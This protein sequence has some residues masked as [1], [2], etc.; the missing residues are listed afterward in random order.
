MKRRTLLQSALALSVPA[1]TTAAEST[2]SHTVQYTPRTLYSGLPGFDYASGGV[3]A[4][5]VVCLSGPSCMGK[6][7]LLLD[8]ASRICRRY[9]ARVLFYSAH[10][11]SVY[12]GK[13][14]ALKG[15]VPVWYWEDASSDRGGP[16]VCLLDSNT[17]IAESA[18]E[19]AVKLRGKSPSAAL[20]LILDGWSTL[21]ARSDGMKVIDGIASYPAERWPHTLMSQDLIGRFS[22]FSIMTGMPVVLGVTTAS[23][24]DDEAIATSIALESGIASIANRCVKLHRSALYKV[25]AD[26]GPAERNVVELTGSSPTWWDTRCSKLRFDSRDLGFS[27]VV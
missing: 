13:K 6:T 8:L 22:D 5:E 27:T 26:I 20:V 23:L 21:P 3:G 4:G 17:A 1:A 11:P 19:I 12:I 9:G 2:R 25:T 14:A 7:L 10:K 16:T 15:G 18:F 24:M